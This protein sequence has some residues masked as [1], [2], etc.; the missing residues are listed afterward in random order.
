MFCKLDSDGSSCESTIDQPFFAT[1]DKRNCSTI[2]MKLNFKFLNVNTENVIVEDTTTIMIDNQ[3]VYKKD[4]GDLDES[5]VFGQVIEPASHKVFYS[6]DY[7][8][9]S[10]REE[11]LSVKTDLH[12][13][14]TTIPTVY[15]Q[16]KFLHV[17][18][19]DMILV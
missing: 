4:G 19:N 6:I 18:V 14:S 13:K 8:F 12:V 15:A 2:P 7:N 5:T 16:C 1:I 17:Y 3:S 9:D 11:P 10:C